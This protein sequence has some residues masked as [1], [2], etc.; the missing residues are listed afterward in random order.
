M[1][2]I[3]KLF[4]QSPIVPLQAHMAK[5]AQC[6]EK[7]TQ[8]FDALRQGD[9]A[10]IEKLAEET[11]ALEYEADWLRIGTAIFGPRT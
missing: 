10:L 3:S 1:R 2:T 11:S 5:V 8:M 7:I 9:Q 6:V 4:G